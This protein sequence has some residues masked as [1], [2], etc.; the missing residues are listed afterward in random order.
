MS[1]STSDDWRRRDF[2][3]RSALA[4]VASLFSVTPEPVAAEP[5][6]ETTRIKLRDVPAA[7]L[8][9]QYI[10]E[11][12]LKAEGFTDVRFVKLADPGYQTY[13]R[14]SLPYRRPSLPARSISSR[15]TCWPGCW[16]WTVT[17]R[18]SSSLAVCTL[19]ATNCSAP[20]LS[21]RFSISRASGSL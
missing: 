21:T 9:P 11:E 8:V 7:C 6:P 10:A 1:P 20:A 15:M 14:P 13:R 19:A 2:L 12:M 17:R 3:T 4:G 5:P 16:S 18:R